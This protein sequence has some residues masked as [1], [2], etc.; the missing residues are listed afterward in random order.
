MRKFVLVLFVMVMIPYVTTLA[1]TGRLGGAGA[2]AAG[3]AGA[4]TSGPGT[5]GMSGMSGAFGAP[6]APGAAGG[7]GPGD[8]PE[9][10][11]L[12]S[13]E[14]VIVLQN[15]REVPV[16][17]EEFLTG[18]LAAQIPAEYGMETLKAQAVLARTY[19]YRELDGK[20][21]I[22][23]EALDLDVLDRSQME[24]FWG[25][26]RFPEAYGRLERAVEETR[27]L[28]LVGDGILIEPFFCRAAAGRTRSGGEAYPYLKQAESPGDVKAEGYLSITDWSPAVM[29]D[30]M[31]QIPDAVPVT[32]GELPG[33]LQ[34]VER[35]GAGYVRQIQ[36][37][38]KT[39]TGEE[40]QYA[41]GL[42]S[43]AYTFSPLDGKI[44]VT[45]KGIGHGY[46]FSQAG[47]A[48]LET[49]GADFEA[50]IFHYFQ[51]VDLIKISDFTE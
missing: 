3:P 38:T 20:D 49:E 10:P 8:F 51:N 46:G 39:Y 40:V 12:G 17:V 43:S 41:L 27:G 23:E 16:P 24:K 31:N 15:G 9:S 35:D 7:S 25:T 34:I 22:P 19:I 26:S 30:R 32:A 1:W 29:A 44:R 42:P 18:V 28:V 4:G 11:A 50:L 33:E 14:A 13:S 6:G 37:G 48:Q 2:G 47:A 45:V 36:V 21:S 5:A